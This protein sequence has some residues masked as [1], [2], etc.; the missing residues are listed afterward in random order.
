MRSAKLEAIER[1]RE[2][3]TKALEIWVN[4]TITPIVEE[5]DR[6]SKE[7]FKEEYRRVRKLEEE[8]NSLL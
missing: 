4:E 1:V 6:R 7:I 3:K 5:L 2:I 8:V